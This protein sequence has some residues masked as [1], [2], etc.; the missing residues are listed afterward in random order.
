MDDTR[1]VTKDGQQQVDEQICA[2]AT[3]KEDSK[4]WQKDGED[5]FDDVAMNE[6]SRVLDCA[7][8]SAGMPRSS[9]ATARLRGLPS[10]ERH[11]VGCVKEIVL[12]VFLVG[13]NLVLCD[14]R[15]RADGRE[16]NIYWVDWVVALT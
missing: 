1:D 9:G 11:G 5:D 2:T 15:R 10:G 6:V 3:L 13:L 12:I 7:G 4:W 8:S 16:T 14:G